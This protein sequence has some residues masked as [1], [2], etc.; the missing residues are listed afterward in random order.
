MKEKYSAKA[1]A[2]EYFD[3]F[4]GTTF[5]QE[6]NQMRIAMLT[7]RKH[8]ALLNNYGNW[9]ESSQELEKL[10]AINLFDHASKINAAYIKENFEHIDTQK[11]EEYKN[12]R[13]PSA[14]KVYSFDSGDTRSYPSPT[15]DKNKLY[16]IFLDYLL[17]LLKNSQII[18]R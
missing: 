3:F 18:I 12:F 2:L 10:A 7:G 11:L 8:V 4:Y 15:M 14:W 6:W 5:G 16:S 17:S 1:I 13:V 9:V